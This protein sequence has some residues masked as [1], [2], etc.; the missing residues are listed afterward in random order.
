MHK[1]PKSFYQVCPTEYATGSNII[2]LAG[3]N[4]AVPN[5]QLET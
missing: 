1:K 4:S 2:T 5:G 3:L